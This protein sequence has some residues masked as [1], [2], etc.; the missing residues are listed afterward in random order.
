M[1]GSESSD[2]HRSSP[3][4]DRDRGLH[5]DAWTIVIFIERTVAQFVETVGFPSDGRRQ[6]SLIARS[7]PHVSYL[8]SIRQL[9][10]FVEEIHDRGAIEPRSWLLQRGIKKTILPTESDGDRLS[11]N[12]TIDARWWLRLKRNQGQFTANSGTTTSSIETAPTMPT[13]R[14][15]D[16]IKWP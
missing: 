10:R 6:G 5:Q 2:H 8:I 13:N 16:R 1:E 11:T 9:G 4:I 14:A 15:H 12:I 3:I 7:R